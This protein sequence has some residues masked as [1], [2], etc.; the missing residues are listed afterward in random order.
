[1]IA[2]AADL[3][4]KTGLD[5]GF[6]FWPAAHISFGLSLFYGIQKLFKQLE[7]PLT[8]DTKSGITRWLRTFELS[9]PLHRW[10]STF[11]QLFDKAFGENHWSWTCF[12]R[13]CAVTIVTLIAVLVGTFLV[14]HGSF[15]FID[16]PDWA[17][18]DQPALTGFKLSIFLCYL[19]Y[20]SISSFLPDYIS[21]WKTRKFLH[22]PQ[23]DEHRSR[24]LLI[25]L[26]DAILSFALATFAA[27]TAA[28]L[29]LLTWNFFTS[30]TRITGEEEIREILTSAGLQTVLLT[31][32][33]AF[34][35]R[36]WSASYAGSGLL[37]IL[38]RRLDVLSRWINQHFD[39]EKHPLQVIGLVAGTAAALAYWT[40]ALLS[41]LLSKRFVA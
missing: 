41:M 37:L 34:F 28:C 4:P 25:L 21:L 27:F 15:F 7:D 12:S 36:I 16:P 38:A 30:F 8:V 6:L 26:A 13:S 31:F 19:F 23:D 29:V 10:P 2:H 35:G 33:P 14:R 22:I 11:V 17:T 32:V 20:S 39:I 3:S 1:V 18:R 9:R 5:L 24:Y 40:L